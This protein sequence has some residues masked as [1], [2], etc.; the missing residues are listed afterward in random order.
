MGP[1]DPEGAVTSR[2]ALAGALCRQ[3][4]GALLMPRAPEDAW[5]M[6]GLAAH[7]EDMVARKWLGQ[8]GDP[9]L[10]TPTG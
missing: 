10:R 7:L 3:W 1:E 4:C 6:E 5:V 8:V 2:L 9:R